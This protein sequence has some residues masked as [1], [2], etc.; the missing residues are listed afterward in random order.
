[1]LAHELVNPLQAIKMAGAAVAELPN[2]GPLAERVETA[3]KRI[4]RILE[5]FAEVSQLPEGGLGIRGRWVDLAPVAQEAVAELRAAHP[6]RKILLELRD[7]A[8]GWFDPDRVAQVVI[9][10]AANALRYGSRP[11]LVTIIVYGRPDDVVVEVHNQ[12]E[13]IAAE[14]FAALLDPRDPRVTKRKAEARGSG[15]GLYLVRAI[16]KGHGGR[17]ELRSSPAEGTTFSAIL[18]RARPT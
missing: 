6:G 3:L 7:D 1:M 14:D 9:N 18:P 5:R 4:R 13:P 10:L 16:V 11:G 8:T 2:G 17:L 15:L 12:G